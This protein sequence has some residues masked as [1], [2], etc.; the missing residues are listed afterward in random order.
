[1][2]AQYTAWLRLNDAPV[3]CFAYAC[4]EPSMTCYNDSSASQLLS[5]LLR[6]DLRSRLV[7]GFERLLHLKVIL[8]KPAFTLV[9]SL[10]P[11]ASLIGI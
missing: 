2:I 4:I 5:L 9:A 7:L 1:M 6:C 8:V 10:P 11:S 3:R